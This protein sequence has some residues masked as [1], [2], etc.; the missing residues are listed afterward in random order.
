MG[1]KLRTELLVILASVIIE[2][3]MIGYAFC[4]G[5]DLLTALIIA[6]VYVPTISASLLIGYLFD[7]IEIRQKNLITEKAS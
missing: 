2:A 7:K 3:G 4:D 1:N 5:F 6:L